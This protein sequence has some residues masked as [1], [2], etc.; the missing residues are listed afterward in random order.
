MNNDQ[1]IIE[2][3]KLVVATET[4]DADPV[5]ETSDFAPQWQSDE[6]KF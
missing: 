4:S 2:S 1:T 6:V 3:E 5:S